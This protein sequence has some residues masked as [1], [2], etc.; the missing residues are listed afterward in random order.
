[1]S[2]NSGQVAVGDKLPE[3]KFKYFDG[4]GNMKVRRSWTVLSMQFVWLVILVAGLLLHDIALPRCKF[5][6][7]TITGLGKMNSLVLLK[8]K[9]VL[10]CCLSGEDI[11]TLCYQSNLA[12]RC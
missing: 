1:M 4:E 3:A 9:G 2:S 5:I 6:Q 12:L 7:S 11:I 8:Y 10:H